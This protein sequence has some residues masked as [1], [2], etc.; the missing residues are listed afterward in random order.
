MAERT[1]DEVRDEIT[2]WIGENWDPE[3]TI[4]EWWQRFGLSGW[5]APT[6]PEEWYGQGLAGDTAAAA[7]AALAEAGVVGPPAGLSVMLAAPTII[8][9]GR[10][11]QKERYCKPII[12]GELAWCQL[13]SEPGAGS[14]LASLQ[15]KAVRD[16]DEWIINGQKVWTSGGQVADMGMLLAR[17]NPDAPKHKGITYFAIDM[18][19]PGVDVRPLREMTGRDVQRGL[20][21]RRARPQR[22]HHRRPQRGLGRRADHVGERGAGL[23]GGGGGGAMGGQPG[24]K[25]ACSR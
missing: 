22:R 12:T 8:A 24:P 21:H 10:D 9:H 20:L 4:G 2:A 14:D 18:N 25:G 7:R 1:A 16:G 13:F 19:Q 11:E 17:T 23:G 6:W 3:L 5:A 15:C